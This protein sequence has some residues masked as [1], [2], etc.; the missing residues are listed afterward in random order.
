[1]DSIIKKTYTIDN[2][3]R[4]VNDANQIMGSIIMEANPNIAWSNLPIEYP[5]EYG[6]ILFTTKNYYYVSQ[7]FI[8]SYTNEMWIR[9]WFEDWTQWRKLSMQ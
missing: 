4:L 2:E 5:N 3:P 9:T 7:M 6:G 1:M 8:Q